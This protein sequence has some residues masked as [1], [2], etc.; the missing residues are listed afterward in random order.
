M[1]RGILDSPARLC[2]GIRQC[3]PFLAPP[4]HDMPRR[5]MSMRLVVYPRNAERYS[6]PHSWPLVSRRGSSAR[7]RHCCSWYPMFWW[8]VQD[9]L[10]PL[11][12]SWRSRGMGIPAEDGRL[13]THLIRA[14]HKP[15]H[16]AAMTVE[17]QEAMQSHV[18]LLLRPG[19]C[20]VAPFGPDSHLPPTEDRRRATIATVHRAYPGKH[21]LAHVRRFGTDRLGVRGKMGGITTGCM[22]SLP[23]AKTFLGKRPSS[24]GAYGVFSFPVV[25]RRMRSMGLRPAAVCPKDAVADVLPGTSFVEAGGRGVQ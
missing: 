19:T 1:G 18:G 3:R 25:M 11:S 17:L 10:L 21:M 15:E 6:Q 12:R 9:V 5:T 22:A 24:G 13:I 20:T 4:F 16:L 8:C 14:A 7:A 2:C 23:L